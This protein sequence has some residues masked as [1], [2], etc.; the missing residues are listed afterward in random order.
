[1]DAWCGWKEAG[2]GEDIKGMSPFCFGWPWDLGKVTSSPPRLLRWGENR[3][4]KFGYYSVANMCKTWDMDLVKIV[5]SA[6]NYYDLGKI[7]LRA[8]MSWVVED[9]IYKWPV[10]YV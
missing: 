8:K 10:V 4:A 5:I 7:F 3:R 6:L 1:M 9:A 2:S